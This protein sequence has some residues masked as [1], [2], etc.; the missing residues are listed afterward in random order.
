MAT[1]FS[2]LVDNKFWVLAKISRLFSRHMF[3]IQSLTVAP[4]INE[5]VSCMTIDVNE[6]EERLRRME[7]ELRK[8]TNVIS[9]H[10]CDETDYV[11]TE[12]VL[13]KIKKSN[14]NFKAFIKEVEKFQARVVYRHEDIEII[15]FS[16]DSSRIEAFLT[17]SLMHKIEEIVRTGTLA[18]SKKG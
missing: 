11:E 13:V 18:I 9:V 6:N 2:V 4:T 16:G 17:T 7:L 12:M 10:I 1:T 8:M 14:P 15:E 3:N 5:K